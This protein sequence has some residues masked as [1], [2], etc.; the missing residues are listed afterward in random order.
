MYENVFSKWDQRFYYCFSKLLVIVL[1][2][3]DSYKLF[4]N[5]GARK[6]C[7][8]IKLFMLKQVDHTNK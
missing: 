8:V 7:L 6:Y 1:F 2:I 5:H 4:F 3:N